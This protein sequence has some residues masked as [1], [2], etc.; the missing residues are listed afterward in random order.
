MVSQTPLQS[1]KPNKSVNS[2]DELSEGFSTKEYVLSPSLQINSNWYTISS[3]ESSLEISV[4]QSPGLSEPTPIYWP[5][6]SIESDKNSISVSSVSSLRSRIENMV[7]TGNPFITWIESS[8]TPTLV[9]PKVS[10]Q[11]MTE[12]SETIDRLES[13]PMTSR[14]QMSSP[15]MSRSQMSSPTMTSTG[16]VPH[17]L[18]PEGLPTKSPREAK[19]KPFEDYLI[20]TGIANTYRLT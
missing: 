16:P 17:P 4:T 19:D 9:S 12:S 5:S 8:F 18:C 7:S 13:S 15:T 1:F 11:T 14:L 2:F 20:R 6:V 10:E 3:I